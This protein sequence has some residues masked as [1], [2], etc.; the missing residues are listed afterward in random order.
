MPGGDGRGPYGTFINC[1]DPATALRRRVRL[2]HT[3]LRK[4]QHIKGTT[5]TSPGATLTMG[6]VAPDA[7]A[8][9]LVTFEVLEQ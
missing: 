8:V 5:A 2:R 7:G 3:L 4:P 1:T 9:V 6:T